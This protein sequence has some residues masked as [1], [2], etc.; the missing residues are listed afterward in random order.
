M[1]LVVSV[2]GLLLTAGLGCLRILR[3]GKG[4]GTVPEKV[5]KVKAELSK[6]LEKFDALAQTT[7]TEWDDRIADLLEP[8]LED[9]AE[10]IVDQLHQEEVVS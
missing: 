3:A 5:T 2:L 1:K 8:P 6:V 7:P 4:S 9:F 10:M